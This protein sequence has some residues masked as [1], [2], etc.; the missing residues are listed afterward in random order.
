MSFLTEEVLRV[1]G[2]IK[3]R[4]LPPRSMHGEQHVQQSSMKSSSPRKHH[5]LDKP[6]S[7]EDES[8]DEDQASTTSEIEPF[9]F[10]D[11]PAELRVR[12]Y[13]VL[14]SPSGFVEGY[15][16]DEIF[17]AIVRTTKQIHHE[18]RAMLYENTFYMKMSIR[19]GA[20]SL[21]ERSYV[22][23]V[24]LGLLE[25][26]VI[27]LDLAHIHSTN[28]NVFDHVDWRPLQAMVRLKEVRLFSI[29]HKN[30]DSGPERVAAMMERVME[31]IPKACVVRYGK[32][33]SMDLNA[34]QY[35]MEIASHNG[36]RDPIEIDDAL[37]ER[38][39]KDVEGAQGSKSGHIRDYRYPEKQA[40]ALKP[41]FPEHGGPS[42][43]DGIVLATSL[44]FA[45]VFS[46]T[47]GLPSRA[48]GPLSFGFSQ[49]SDQEAVSSQPATASS[50]HLAFGS[51]SASLRPQFPWTKLTGITTSIQLDKQKVGSTRI[52]TSEVER[53]TSVNSDGSFRDPLIDTVERAIQGRLTPFGGDTV[54][55]EY[56]GRDDNGDGGPDTAALLHALEATKQGS[57]E[58]FNFI[59]FLFDKTVESSDHQQRLPSRNSTELA[60]GD[61]EARLM[62]LEKTLVPL[63]HAKLVE[64]G[65]CHAEPDRHGIILDNKAR[66]ICHGA[67][68]ASSKLAVLELLKEES[69]ATKAKASA[70]EDICSWLWE[71]LEKGRPA[72]EKPSGSAVVGAKFHSIGIS[73]MASAHA[74]AQSRYAAQLKS[75]R[76]AAPTASMP[77]NWDAE[78]DTACSCARTLTKRAPTPKQL[79]VF[80][81]EALKSLEAVMI[82]TM[83]SNFG[84]EAI[85]ARD[86]VVS[87][88]VS[89]LG[90]AALR[91]DTA[92]TKAIWV[93]VL[94]A[95][96][97]KTSLK[98]IKQIDKVFNAAFQHLLANQIAFR[99]L[100]LPPELRTGIYKDLLA[101]GKIAMTSCEH[102]SALRT[103][104]KAKLSLLSVCKQIHS[105]AK[106][107]IY[108]NRIIIDGVTCSAPLWMLPRQ[109][110]PLHILPQLRSLEVAL[111][112]ETVVSDWSQL[113][114]MT[115]LKRPSVAFVETSHI[116]PAHR[117]RVIRDITAAAPTDCHLIFG[118]DTMAHARCHERAL[119]LTSDNT[120]WVVPDQESVTS[121]VR[122][123]R[124][125]ASRPFSFVVREAKYD[126]GDPYDS[127]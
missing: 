40:F 122:K 103:D 104:S 54:L 55:S 51:S 50:S 62:K 53:S 124:K 58:L 21:F 42:T 35:A 48:D 49:P 95:L 75:G 114:R 39:G 102:D 96:G 113:Q 8:D 111:A 29:D 47:G 117:A 97:S 119:K 43:D 74:K 112:V 66:V 33:S 52:E 34:Q 30:S 116:E 90:N 4:I 25:K 71:V 110:L 27:L 60:E 73:R 59:R 26:A 86:E 101:P 106:G 64:I 126:L 12:I 125:I 81:R 63:V 46:F 20:N 67:V 23:D 82:A 10:M 28:N 14:L 61:R 16:R 38:C 120:T 108:E 37:L 91:E 6:L 89:T 98:M 107:L 22:S 79:P 9:R 92:V 24:G 11:L 118:S 68:L 94:Q 7:I 78:D 72:P 105:E 41:L 17:T 45:M 77:R 57:P 109:Q 115:G 3:P 127:S 36:D 99:F 31:R 80:T 19:L 93:E 69:C 87:K 70:I 121:A 15:N 2:P 44:G 13:R 83:R 76:Y 100:D 32:A 5:G 18:A 65:V 85:V 1:Q 56:T 123:A 88:L 84:G